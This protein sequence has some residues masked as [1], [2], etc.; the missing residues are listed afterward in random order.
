MSSGGGSETTEKRSK[1]LLKFALLTPRWPLRLV[2][3][4]PPP[5]L[6]W[7]SNGLAPFPIDPNP[8]DWDE[9][10]DTVGIPNW[11]RPADGDPPPR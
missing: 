5:G 2:V 1:S 4:A 3:A 11:K 8:E 6:P 10:L 9:H 7:V